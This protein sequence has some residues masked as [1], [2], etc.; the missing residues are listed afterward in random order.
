MPTTPLIKLLN[1]R[2]KYTSHTIPHLTL[3]PHAFCYTHVENLLK[4]PASQMLILSIYVKT[5]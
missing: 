2:K 5:T 1:F 3:F 4:G